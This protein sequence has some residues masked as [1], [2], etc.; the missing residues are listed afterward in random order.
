MSFLEARMGD[1]LSLGFQSVAGYNTQI[2]T[3]DN[4]RE[5]RNANWSR[6][7]RRYSAAHTSFQV[8]H[9]PALV[10]LFHAVRG[11]AHGFR[12]KDHTDYQCTAESLGTAPGSGSA[13]VQLTKT[14]T[15]GALSTVRNITKP[16][17]A[18][19]YVG[20]VAKTGTLDTATG[21]FTPT[22]AWAGGALTWT[23][24]FDVPVRFTSDELPAVI[25]T[26]TA[27]GIYVIRCAIELV[28]IF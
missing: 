24:E 4:G 16:V 22:T 9:F 8:A 18:T 7:K 27:G 15:N 3:L 10:A 26:K 6:A 12:F 14:Y 23:G 19:V 5:Q 1:L 28:E 20:G 25:E 2:V 13:A 21:L 11:S 17:S